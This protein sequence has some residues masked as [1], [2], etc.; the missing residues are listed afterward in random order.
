MNQSLPNNSSTVP[1]QQPS[2]RLPFS[3]FSQELRRTR[4]LP[5]HQLPPLP[6]RP[7][8][9]AKSQPTTKEAKLVRRITGAAHGVTHTG[10]SHGTTTTPRRMGTPRYLVSR[11]MFPSSTDNPHT[12]TGSLRS[13]ASHRSLGVLSLSSGAREIV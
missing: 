10:D 11:A 7:L 13:S 5:K 1:R 3:L 12:S 4:R 6:R 9:L 2:I 8:L